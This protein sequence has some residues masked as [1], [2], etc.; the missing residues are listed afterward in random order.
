MFE[1]IPLND[2]YVADFVDETLEFVYGGIYKSTTIIHH[3]DIKKEKSIF[4]WMADQDG[5]FAGYL[6]LFDNKIYKP[7]TTS[8]YDYE[9]V[10]DCPSIDVGN[11]NDG[12]INFEPLS[13]FNS[14]YIKPFMSIR[15]AKKAVNDINKQREKEKIKS[16]I[17]KN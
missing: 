11:T 2:I 16:L 1:K 17:F 3:F 6:N 12:Y 9:E 10:F 15:L 7:I 14:K 8:L 5:K 4:I 13:N